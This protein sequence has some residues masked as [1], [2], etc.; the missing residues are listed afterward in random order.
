MTNE[1]SA[2][3]AESSTEAAERNQ[4]T[5][6]PAGPGRLD[7]FF[8][9]FALGVAPFLVGTALSQALALN[10]D[11]FLPV[12]TGIGV[13]FIVCAVVAWAI[14][15][16]DVRGKQFAFDLAI[17]ATAALGWGVLGF[18]ISESEDGGAILFWLTMLMLGVIAVWVCTKIPAARREWQLRRKTKT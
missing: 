5:P 17:A 14:V 13:V 7:R 10:P 3:Q 16:D 15:H 2:N 18:F 12:L 11:L 4:A 1:H 8:G 9:S 6:Q